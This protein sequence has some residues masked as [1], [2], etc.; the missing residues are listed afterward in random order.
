MDNKVRGQGGGWIQVGSRSDKAIGIFTNDPK[1]WLP[2]HCQKG[3][4]NSDGGVAGDQVWYRMGNEACRPQR[5]LV[6]V[7]GHFSQQRTK[8]VSSGFTHCSRQER[9]CLSRLLTP[10]LP[11]L[12]SPFL[13]SG[14]GTPAETER[15]RRLDALSAG[16]LASTGR[17]AVF[18][19]LSGSR[20]WPLPW[21]DNRRRGKRRRQSRR[22]IWWAAHQR[23]EHTGFGGVWCN[24][25]ACWN[26]IW[27]EMPGF[28]MPPVPIRGAEQPKAAGDVFNGCSVV[29]SAQRLQLQHGKQLMDGMQRT[30]VLCQLVPASLRGAWGHVESVFPPMPVPRQ[31]SAPLI[32]PEETAALRRKDTAA[33]NIQWWFGGLA[34]VGCCATVVLDDTSPSWP[35]WRETRR[36]PFGKTLGSQTEQGK[37]LFKLFGDCRGKSRLI[38]TAQKEAISDKRLPLQLSFSGLAAVAACMRFITTASTTCPLDEETERDG[39]GG[40]LQP[41]STVASGTAQISSRTERVRVV[42]T[43][44]T[45]GSLGLVLRSSARSSACSALPFLDFSRFP[46]GPAS[47]KWHGKHGAGTLGDAA[48]EPS[49]PHRRLPSQLNAN[50]G[51]SRQ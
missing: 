50:S 22:L 49:R 36:Y 23:G 8:S 21:V 10:C 37:H 43:W 11:V 26:A 28:E 19:G 6:M 42:K 9:L 40:W 31:T 46:S 25:T 34:V 27:C 30:R 32:P 20:V 2:G 14:R 51:R 17:G 29:G 44:H 3:G 13:L 47:K 39:C 15:S 16:G 41:L 35:S 24:S 45:A 5:L 7:R 4:S 33:D 12:P 48:I 1:A 18:C 38:P